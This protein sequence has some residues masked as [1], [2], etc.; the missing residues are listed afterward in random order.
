MYRYTYSI[1]I[2]FVVNILKQKRYIYIKPLLN[3]K[4]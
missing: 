2:F 1:F 3:A 4:L